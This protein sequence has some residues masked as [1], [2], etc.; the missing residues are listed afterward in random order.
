MTPKKH[1]VRKP[2]YTLPNGS[3]IPSMGKEFNKKE[4]AFIFWYTNPKYESFMNAGRAAVRAGYKPENAVVYGYQLKRKLEISKKIDEILEN[5]K[6]GMKGLIYRIAFICRDRMF[7][8]II[9][10]YRQIKRPVKPYKVKLSDG[11]W[12]ER[13]WVY[14]FE[15]IPLDEISARNRMCIDGITYKG[16]NSDVFYKLPNRDKAADNFFKCIEIL[17]GKSRGKY[18]AMLFSSVTKT[19]ETITKPLKLLVKAGTIYIIAKK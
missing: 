14:T 9:D 2:T 8:N 16:P 18:L 7:F 6:E 4:S 12:E 15:A 17:Y 13:T 5:T 19:A 11:T 1:I 10:F 3:P